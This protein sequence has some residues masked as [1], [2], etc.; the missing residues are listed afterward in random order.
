[1]LAGMVAETGKT[2]EVK[3]ALANSLGFFGVTPVTLAGVV[4]VKLNN[5]YEPSLPIRSIQLQIGC[6]ESLESG[7]FRSSKKEQALWESVHDLWNPKA[8]T[9]ELPCPTDVWD[10]PFK[11]RIPLEV[12]DR[13]SGCKD[14][15]E[16]RVKWRLTVI[17]NHKPIP[18]VGHRVARAWPL[19]LR[20]HRTRPTATLPP[21]PPS[22][23]TIGTGSTATQIHVNPPPGCYGPLDTFPLSVSVRPEDLTTSVRKVSV[24]LERRLELVDPRRPSPPP[25]EGAP[26][27]KAS[28]ISAIFN[29]SSSPRSRHDDDGAAASSRTVTTV[30][31]ETTLEVSTRGKTGSSWCAGFLTIPQRNHRWDIGQTEQTGLVDVSF[32]IRVKATVKSRRHNSVKELVSGPVPVVILAT[33][34]SERATAT[35][36]VKRP[37]SSDTSLNIPPATSDDLK[38]KVSLHGSP[39]LEL[40]D[41]DPSLDEPRLASKTRGSRAIS[42]NGLLGPPPPPYSDRGRC[43]TPTVSSSGTSSTATSPT[44]ATFAPLPSVRS[45]LRYSSPRPGPRPC[46]SSPQSTGIMSPPSSS[47]DPRDHDSDSVTVNGG[48]RRISMSASE[49][50]DLQPVRSRQ[51]L[52]RSS[53]LVFGL[54]R[55]PSSTD[56]KK[57]PPRANNR[58][59][60][61][62]TLGLGLPQVPDSG[63]PLRRPSTAPGPASFGV[64]SANVSTDDLRPR[65]SGNV[66]FAFSMPLGRKYDQDRFV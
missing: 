36:A 41:S 58:L 26:P 66:A 48:R 1:M 13:S 53:D 37:D 22:G 33:T 43:T 8:G 6:Y 49:D 4:H 7:L 30:I 5:D 62:D 65:S 3:S 19:D 17:V 57:R 14:F 10:H 27:H 35:L 32:V 40:E 9:H 38:H 11:V 59:P 12:A 39:P 61:L 64:Y 50:N 47:V 24:V 18:Y 21:S 56:A 29:R 16:W 23:V 45:I 15:R 52:W 51:K 54:V 2:M 55:A 28:R 25:D 44:S 20:D 63:R 60:S 42:E 31:R 46:S 34:A